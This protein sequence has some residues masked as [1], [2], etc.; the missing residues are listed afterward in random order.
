MRVFLV[1]EEKLGFYKNVLPPELYKKNPVLIAASE[2]NRAGDEKSCGVLALLEYDSSW[3]IEY[4]YVDKS[5]RMKGVGSAMVALAKDLSRATVSAGLFVSYVRHK[6]DKGLDEFFEK[7]GLAVSSESRLLSV[8]FMDIQSDGVLEN[9][10]KPPAVIRPL[11]KVS[12]RDYALLGDLI[13]A[14]GDASAVKSDDVYLKLSDRREYHS[15]ISYVYFDADATPCGCVLLSARRQGIVVD[16]LYVKKSITPVLRMRIVMSML[17]EAVYSALD[18]V[19]L[20][21]SIYI[22]AVNPEAERI[23]NMIVGGAVREYGASV[24]RVG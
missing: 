15:G 18:E 10:I 7:C 23:L 12:E 9:S 11:S 6:D 2:S 17:R 16:Y 20:G 21:T 24:E 1:P 14:D 22:N 8:S 19:E 5:Y 4:I 13:E 3:E